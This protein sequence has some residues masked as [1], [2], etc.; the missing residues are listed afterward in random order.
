MINFDK[1]N[2]QYMSFILDS[3]LDDEFEFD[4]LND[5]KSNVINIR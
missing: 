1:D 2:R 5:S 4:F 3:H